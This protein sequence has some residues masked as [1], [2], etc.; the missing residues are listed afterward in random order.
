MD[1]DLITSQI[2]G[3][4]FQPGNLLHP[5]P[6]SEHQHDRG[7]VSAVMDHLEEPAHLF[8]SQRAGQWPGQAQGKGGQPWPGMDICKGCPL[9]KYEEV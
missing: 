1:K 2:Q 8:I 9:L 5:Q 3:H 4:Q 6:A 7:P